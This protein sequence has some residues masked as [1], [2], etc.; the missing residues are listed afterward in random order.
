MRFLTFVFSILL[1]LFSLAQ[2]ASSYAVHL[3]IEVLESPNR[4]ELSWTSDASA[5]SYNIYR[6]TPSAQTFGA[7]YAT[8]TGSDT[9][10][11]DTDI[12][13]GEAY[14]YAI[15]KYTNSYTGYG[16]A[17]GGI[18]VKL[19]TTR[20]D[21]LLIIE[22]DVQD[23]LS[24]EMA[25]L[26]EDLVLD[27]W[28]VTQE[29]VSRDT[30]VEY[31]KDL[32]LDMEDEL[33]NLEMIYL[34]GHVPVPYSGNLAPD[35]HSNHVGAWPADAYYAELNGTWTDNSVTNTTAADTR[36]H[37]VPSDGKFD[38][39][40]LPSP[41]ELMISRVDFA[42]LPVFSE[43]EI[44]LTRR[45]L[46]RV[47]A[48]KN[49]DWTLEKRA[50]ID[51]NFG[52]FN[53]EAF[54][55]NGWRNFAPLVGKDQIFAAD[56]RTTLATDEYLFAY[57]CGGGSFTS[58]SGIG[59]SAQLATD[60]LLTGFTMMFGSYFGDWDRPDNFLRSSLAQGRT[61]SVSWAGRPHWHY[62]SMGLG[63]PIGYGTKISQNNST[64]YHAS[65]GA[66]FVHIAQLGDPS[67]RI[68]YPRPASSVSVDTVDTFHVLVSW[69]ASQD[70][71]VEGYFVYQ[72]TMDSPW[73]RKNDEPIVGTSFIDSCMIYAGSYEY[74]VRATRLDADFSGSYYNESLGSTA[75][76]TIKTTK[77]ADG[78]GDF[79][80]D[81]D[82][83]PVTGAFVGSY[84]SWVTDF[85]WEVDGNTLTGNNAS[86][87]TGI[88]N[89]QLLNYTYELS[90]VC[91][92]IGETRSLTLSVNHV[93]EQSFAI[94]PNPAASESMIQIDADGPI[95]AIRIY[96]MDGRQVVHYS[97]V[98]GA[99][100][101]PQM[102]SGVYQI[103][104]DLENETKYSTL[105]VQ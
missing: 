51:D 42:N 80:Q 46:N 91:S 98:N 15:R 88:S 49:G 105:I 36:N 93:E 81:P 47:H 87:E 97:N 57:G 92:A 100:G 21:I 70:A 63:H 43:D 65:Y 14:E 48:Y 19:Q 1:P 23:N 3:Q 13:I 85:R 22:T 90:N 6:K 5:T 58:A 74:M 71:S 104:C 29:E 83:D 12:T 56:Y 8:V 78:V 39:S 53:G 95:H 45:Y 73:F 77:T 50:L 26:V 17:M 59:T 31:V 10:Y 82:S 28:K 25:E 24:A 67:L 4:L 37:N 72:R 33:D 54:A 102:P 16:Y 18:E 11:I 84:L 44:E 68:E 61:M 52:G 75:S 40:T 96:T 7:I 101:L 76:L 89:G 69:T 41:V 20:G 86:Y 99:V 55:A 30:T 38:Q 27:G 60:S 79:V 2:A 35:A 103:Q 9:T 32:I 66:Q 64:L 62:H 34:L 94:F